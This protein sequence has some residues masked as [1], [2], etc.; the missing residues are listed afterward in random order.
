MLNRKRKG[1][2]EKRMMSRT[3]M[4]PVS[5][6]KDSTEVNSRDLRASAPR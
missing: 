6:I 1:E 4:S 3:F 5:H 2:V